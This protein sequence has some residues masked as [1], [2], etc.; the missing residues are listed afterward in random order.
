MRL[1]RK[2]FHLG[3]VATGLL[4]CVAH[5]THLEDRSTYIAPLAAQGIVVDG[6]ADDVAWAKAEWREIKYRWLGPEYTAEDFNGRFKVVWTADRL[7]LLAEIEDDILFDSHRNPLVQYWDDDCL[8][9][10]IDEDYSGGDHQFSHNAFAYHMSLDNRAIDIGADGE[11]RDYTHHTESRWRQEGDK[12]IW[13]VSFQIYDDSYVDDSEDNQPVA[14]S[15]GKVLGL[16]VAYCDNDGSE[17]R[18]NFIG[19]ESVPTGA[20][21]RGYIDAGLFGK[22]E[23]HE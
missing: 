12:V 23:L 15:A 1:L 18:E 17:L 4:G 21:D 2:S 20:K 19:S 6:V 8:E 7:Y 9:V 5:A 10:F 13:E 3:I 14:L 16:M 11:K 22:V